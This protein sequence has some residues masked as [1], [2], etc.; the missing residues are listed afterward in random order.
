MSTYLFGVGTLTP[1]QRFIFVEAMHE[2]RPER[3]QPHPKLETL[4]QSR[5][6]GTCA[7]KPSHTVNCAMEQAL[8]LTESGNDYGKTCSVAVLATILFAQ[9]RFVASFF[10]FF[11]PYLCGGLCSRVSRGTSVRSSVV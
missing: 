10:N 8:R 6:E 5:V 1:R 2:C 9:L 11:V 7:F 4:K 3:Q